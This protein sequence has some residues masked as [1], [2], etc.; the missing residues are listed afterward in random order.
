MTVNR[1]VVPVG[2]VTLLLA[3][4]VLAG[5]GVVTQKLT[6]SS[7]HD[8]VR[9]QGLRLDGHWQRTA[10]AVWTNALLTDPLHSSVVWAG[11]NDGVWRSS[12]GGTTWHRAATG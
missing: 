11:T 3:A 5:K 7:A 8:G 6:A 10:L 12:D 2:V 1:T 4:G 9:W